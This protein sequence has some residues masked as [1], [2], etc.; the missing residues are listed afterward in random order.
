MSPMLSTSQPHH[1]QLPQERVDSAYGT[2]SNRTGSPPQKANESPNSSSNSNGS[3]VAFNNNTYMTTEPSADKVNNHNGG[4]KSDDNTYM[5][6]HNN[7]NS[8]HDAKL[9]KRSPV[10]RD[11]T[12]GFAHISS[13]DQLMKRKMTILVPSLD[14][15]ISLE[16]LNPTKD[17][18]VANVSNHDYENM[19]LININR[20]PIGGGGGVAHWRTY[21]DMANDNHEE[22]TA[23]ERQNYYDIYPLSKQM[24]E[25]LYRSL[26]PLSTAATVASDSVLSDATY[27]PIEAYDDDAA[28]NAV[29]VTLIHH[30]GDKLSTRRITSM[31]SLREVILQHEAVPMDDP[32]DRADLYI[33]APMRLLSPIMEESETYHNATNRTNIDLNRSIMTVISEILQN[34]TYAQVPNQ[35]QQPQMNN[36]QHP[37]GQ[38]QDSIE[39]TSSTLVHTIDEIR[40]NSLCNLYYYEK[41]AASTSAIKSSSSNM[42]PA[43]QVPPRNEQGGQHG[44]QGLVSK[45]RP[46]VTVSTSETI[47]EELPD[48]LDAVQERRKKSP[49]YTSVGS[50]KNLLELAGTTNHILNTPK[51]AAS[52]PKLSI[53]DPAKLEQLE[54]PKKHFD[55]STLK[56]FENSHSLSP[57]AKYDTPTPPLKSNQFVRNTNIYRPRRK[58]SMLRDRFEAA[59]NSPKQKR[60]MILAK[61][62][63]NDLYENISDD[64]LMLRTNSIKNKANRMDK[65]KSVPT[66]VN[67]N[68]LLRPDEQYEQQE[69]QPQRNQWSTASYQRSETHLRGQRNTNARRSMSILDEQVVY[70]KENR[71]PSSHHPPA[72]KPCLKDKAPQPPPP[73]RPKLR[74]VDVLRGSPN[75][76]RSGGA[77]LSPQSKIFSRR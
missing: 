55:R 53:L 62:S 6:V 7:S 52:P 63:S 54:L 5:S 43:P 4:D 45:Q 48:D 64:F 69:Q 19:A 16:V 67:S 44:Q 21:S 72:P 17:P 28:K 42:K 15:T 41:P 73:L 1:G 57:S 2:D 29:P 27:E 3:S 34:R 58:F 60:P 12:S 39:S 33:L 20:N 70:D 31:D 59:D 40:N 51:K 47:A 25:Q 66:F 13:T 38:F 18:S 77:S 24:K 36:Q 26:T 10:V 14:K 37:D 35:P 46:I 68:E 65:C 22:S 56:P 8:D 11:V 76:Y 23:Y 74:S 75:A 32:Q 71:H 9:L 49:L 30:D 61:R 50:R